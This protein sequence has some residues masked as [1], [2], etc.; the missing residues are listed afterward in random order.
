MKKLLNYL[1]NLR[2]DVFKILPMKESEIEGVD[3]HLNDYIETLIINMN[4]AHINY[5]VLAEEKQFLYVI[6]NLQYL[7]NKKVGFSTW[8]K[9]I[10]NSTKSVDDLCINYGGVDYGKRRV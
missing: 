7:L 1:L 5:P 8:R 2:S 6:N 9:V 4:G 3:N 10:L